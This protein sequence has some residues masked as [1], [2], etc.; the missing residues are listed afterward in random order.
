MF[1]WANARRRHSW[2]RRSKKRCSS[3][4]KRPNSSSRG[5]PAAPWRA[6][7]GQRSKSSRPIP[8]RL[9][10]LHSSFCI[11]YFAV[12]ILQL[13]LSCKT[14]KPTK[15]YVGASEKHRV[16]RADRPYTVRK[17]SPHRR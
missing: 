15:L 6:E 13:A 10:I 16:L 11:F 9:T 8:R 12:S 17:F 4:E 2:L 14:E 3:R 7:R 1:P 5:L